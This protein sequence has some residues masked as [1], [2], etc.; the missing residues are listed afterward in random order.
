MNLEETNK[1]NII[2]RKKGKARYLRGHK[3]IFKM[4]FAWTIQKMYSFPQSNIDTWNGLKEE[5]IMTKN[6]L[7]STERKTGQM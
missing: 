3:K 5:V 1:E 6:V 7:T 2:L 4:E